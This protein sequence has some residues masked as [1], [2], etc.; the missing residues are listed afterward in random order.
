MDGTSHYLN[1]F[2]TRDS[3]QPNMPRL[4]QFEASPERSTDYAECWAWIHMLLETIPQRRELLQDYL[5]AIRREGPPEALS[6]R[7]GAVNGAS[8]PGAA[9]T[10]DLFDCV[11]IKSRSPG[12]GRS[13]QQKTP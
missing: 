6:A 2:A 8:K 11:A 13:R 5:R 4:E 10:P 1:S 3:W 7:V 12:A 9:R